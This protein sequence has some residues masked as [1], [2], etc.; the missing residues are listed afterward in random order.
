MEV[1][2]SLRGRLYRIVVAIVLAGV[3]THVLG[4]VLD[5]DDDADD[6][7]DEGGAPRL[8]RIE[9]QP[10]V[11]IPRQS[12]DAVGLKLATLG[13][14]EYQPEHHGWAVVVDRL[15][16]SESTRRYDGA[17]AALDVA[18]ADLRRARQTDKRLRALGQ[19]STTRARQE[20]AQA[21][22]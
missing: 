12:W 15:P 3:F 20:D 4:Q 14:V 2:K 18:A 16:L 11:H 5:A 7:A 9:G 1:H 17:T 6:V 8:T 10:A 21:D 19:G 13:S 22:L